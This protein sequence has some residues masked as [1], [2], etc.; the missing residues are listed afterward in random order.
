MT[1]AMRGPG[2]FLAQ[3]MGEAPFDTMASAC[4]WMAE[5]GYEGV[6]VPS[7][8]ARCMD[9]ALAAESDTYCDDLK[10]RC[11]EAGVAITELDV[12]DWRLPSDPSSRDAAAAALVDRFLGTVLSEA[13]PDFIATWGLS[14]RYSWVG[15][16]FP[17]GDGARAR[18]LPLDRDLRPKALFD[19]IRRY[20]R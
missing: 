20:T 2:I 12:I 19:V 9:L 16:T 3:F 18:P 11:A 5:A 4:R 17:R 15:E 7:N 8:D 1:G 13:T 14:D 6:Q 10:G